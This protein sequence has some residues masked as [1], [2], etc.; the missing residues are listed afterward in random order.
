MKIAFLTPH[1]IIGGAETY[2]IT[3]SAWLVDHGHSVV[4]ISDG[5]VNV[6]NL[7]S[8][9]KHIEFKTEVSPASFSP[10]GYRKYITEL[11]AILQAEQADIVEAHNTS[12]A[13]HAAISFRNTGIPYFINILNERTYVRNPFLCRITKNIAPFGLFYTLTSQM[14]AYVS[15]CVGISVDA[16]IL[17]IPIKGIDSLGAGHQG[18]YILTVCRMA[19]DKMYVK[20]LIRDFIMLHLEARIPSDYRLLVVGDGVLRDEVQVIA[21]QNA[22]V[23]Q[24]LGTVVGDELANLYRN[25]EIY[26]GTGTSLLLGASCG[27]P[28]LIPGFTIATMPYCFGIWGERTEDKNVL[29]VSELQNYS[30]TTYATT[31]AKLINNP[32]MRIDAAQKA[33]ELF[34][35]S[36]AFEPI[37]EQWEREYSKIR[38]VFADKGKKNEIYVKSDISTTVN[39]YRPLWQLSNLV[40]KR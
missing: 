2:I 24:L 38:T 23:V 20:Y 31:L 10:K 17:P 1:M 5:G 7:P 25:A 15:R 39:L 32:S 11:S 28:C 22:D 21:D 8:S 30:C 35:H 33:Q 3:K 19:A 36:Y 6:A 40:R 13:I 27:T 34:N 26:V 29:A 14:Q 16:T 4:V 18:R 9:V 37:M 12:P